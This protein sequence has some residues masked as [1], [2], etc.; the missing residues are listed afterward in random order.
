[1]WFWLIEPLEASLLISPA[2]ITAGDRVIATIQLTRSAPAGGLAF[3]VHADD[4]RIIPPPSVTIPEGNDSVSFAIDVPLGFAPTATVNVT[5]VSG[6]LFGSDSFVV[7]VLTVSLT[8]NPSN[9]NGNATT[10]ATVTLNHPAPAAGVK[11]QLSASSPPDVAITPASITIPKN[12]ANGQFA[13]KA[14]GIRTGTRTVTIRAFFSNAPNTFDE[15][16]LTIMGTPA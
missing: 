16:V 2:T 7:N 6:V 10:T 12:A 9:I 5:A 1:M 15:K 3:T 14:I 8:L 13:V 11:V 4:T